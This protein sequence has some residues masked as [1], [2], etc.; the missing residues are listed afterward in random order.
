M[1]GRAYG[2]RFLFTWPN[3]RV[4]VMGGEQAAQVM[5]IIKREQ[6]ARQGKKLSEKEAEA[7]AAPVRE[8]YEQEGHPYYGTARLWDDGIIEPAKT[9]DA[10]ALCFAAA[11]QAPVEPK[12]TPV[13]R[14]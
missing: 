9:R 6:L 7:I 3:A 5:T 12:K 14:M 4:S 8:Q 10:L 13:F 11:A 1:C 2:P